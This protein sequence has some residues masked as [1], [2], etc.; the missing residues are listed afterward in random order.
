MIIGVIAGIL[1]LAVEL[2]Q[3]ND[4]LELEAKATRAEILLDGWD[5]ITSDPDLVDLMIKD[6]NDE[7]LTEAEEMRL[8]AY[9]MGYFIR[10]EWHY[11]NFPKSDQRFNQVLRLYEAYGSMRRAWGGNSRGSRGA[12]KD[13]LSPEFVTFM[14]ERL[15]VGP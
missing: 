15:T 4:F 5:R 8:N 7:A 2:S 13:N 3:N 1:F 12:G 9:W 11:E 14:D 6:R 10:R